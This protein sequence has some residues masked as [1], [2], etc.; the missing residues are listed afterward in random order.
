MHATNGIHLGCSLLLPVHTV[1]CV[2]T[3]K[4]LVSA[5]DLFPTLVAA[6]TMHAP[7]GPTVMPQCPSDTNMSRQTALCTEGFSLMYGARFRQKF[8]TEDAIGFPRLLASSSCMRVTN[9]IPLGCSLLL[10]VDTVNSVQ[11]LKAVAYQHKRWPL[12]ACGVFA[13]RARGELLRLPCPIHQQQQQQQ[14]Q[15]PSSPK[16]HHR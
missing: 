9:G 1:H 5:V 6:A 16:E 3:L 13:V 14:P 8:T 12:A 4:A 15:K 7:C 10:P 11:T 2:Q